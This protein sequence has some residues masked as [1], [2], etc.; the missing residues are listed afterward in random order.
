MGQFVGLLVMA[1]KMNVLPS[2]LF[3]T[4]CFDGVQADRSIYPKKKIHCVIGRLACFLVASYAAVRGD[5]NEGSFLDV[6]EIF[7]KGSPGQV[8]ILFKEDSES[9]RILTV[10]PWATSRLVT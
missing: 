1:T 3:S 4:Y 6:V 7:P 10:V 9:V 5:S 2:H 8:A